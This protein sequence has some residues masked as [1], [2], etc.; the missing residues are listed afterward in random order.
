V[1]ITLNK[2][3]SKDVF[4]AIR[5]TNKTL[6]LNSDDIQWVFKGGDIT[7][8]S[9][10]VDLSGGEITTLLRDKATI[11]NIPAIGYEMPDNGTLP[12]K[13]TVRFM[14]SS[15]IRNYLG[16]D[17]LYIYHINFQTEELEQIASNVSMTKDNTIEMDI[18]SSNGGYILITKGAARYDNSVPEG[19]DTW[20]SKTGIE[21]FVYR[22]YNVALTR[23]AEEAGLNDWTNRLET[24]TED[25]AKVARG[26]FFSDEFQNKNYTNAQFVE[27]LYKTMFG[28]S[29]DTAGRNYWLSCLDNGVSREYVFHGFAE[30]Q[31]FSELCDK[32]GV[33]R[34]SVGLSLYRDQNVNATGFIAR[35]YTEMLGRDFDEDGLEY[36]CKA[37][38]TK[39]RSIE[40]I[41][42]DGFLHSQ[43]LANQNLSNEEFVTRMYETFLDREPEE[44]GLNDWVGRLERGEVTRDTLVYGFTRSQ[45][46]ANLKAA[47]DLP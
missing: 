14:P 33:T 37:Y 27:L 34:G 20:Q 42:S 18:S 1:D 29:S 47:Y 45:E 41:A 31:E 15:G 28:R 12:G 44:A 6:L 3:I 16:Q 38:I 10:D 40:D 46:F 26:F 13:A 24:K 23:D 7:G 17:G 4:D 19:P 39:E 21:G 30:S 36:W 22:L 25:A 32:F 11:G 2:K 9:K 8:E 35:L 43:E 5:G